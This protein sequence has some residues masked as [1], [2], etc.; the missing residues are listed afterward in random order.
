MIDDLR[1]P[2]GE[3]GPSGPLVIHGNTIP[4]STLDALDPQWTSME[5]EPARSHGR[6]GRGGCGG[7]GEV[8]L[9]PICPKGPDGPK[10][11]SGE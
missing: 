2:D 5:G 10:G 9:G 11:G 1:G 3:R 8:V 4:H 7:G 6:G